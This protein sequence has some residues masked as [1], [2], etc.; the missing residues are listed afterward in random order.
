VQEREIGPLAVVGADRFT[1]PLVSGI[2][3]AELWRGR[4]FGLPDQIGQAIGADLGAVGRAM[5]LTVVVDLDGEGVE[6]A[7]QPVDRHLG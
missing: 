6:E 2:G 1:S 3:G 4:S 7:A 5:L